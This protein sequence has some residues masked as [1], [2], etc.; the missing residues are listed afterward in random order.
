M[1]DFHQVLY[2]NFGRNS[3]DSWLF[4]ALKVPSEGTKTLSGD[5]FQ[6]AMAFAPNLMHRL[7]VSRGDFD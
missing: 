5:I 6:V 2:F 7:Q 1:A 3:N 4:W